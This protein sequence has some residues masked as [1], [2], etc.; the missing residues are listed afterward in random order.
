MTEQEID[1]RAAEL[2]EKRLKAEVIWGDLN[3]ECIALEWAIPALIA[4]GA[5]DVFSRDIAN[6]LVQH[7]HK[8]I[9]AYAVVRKLCDNEEEAKKEMMKIRRSLP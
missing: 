8:E 3:G 9:A 2:T 1:E 5:E 7:R 6:L 4:F